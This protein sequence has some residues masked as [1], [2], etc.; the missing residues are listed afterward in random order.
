MRRIIA[1]VICILGLAAPP[2][3]HAC[4]V[5]VELPEASI[6]DQILAAEVVVFAGPAPENPF[7]YSTRRIFRGSDEKL[8]KAPNIPFLI[9]SVTRRAF[10]ADPTTMV[11][12]IYGPEINDKAG[13]NFSRA[14]R[15]IFVMNPERS[16]FIEQLQANSGLWRLGETD[17]A[18]R[19]SFFS[20]YLWHR[21]QALHDMAMV[22]IGRANYA[23]LRPIGGRVSTSQIME[24]LNDLNRF[25]YWPVAIRLLGLQ[26]DP[27]ARSIVRSRF[28]K[29]LRS[30][31]LHSH[32]WALAGIEADRL[33]AINAIGLALKDRRKTREDKDALV[34]ALSDAGSSQKQFQDEII[35]VFANVLDSDPELTLQIAVATRN[36]GETALH[37]KFEA[38]V[39]LEETDPATQ[40]F[41]NMVLQENAASE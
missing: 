9:D 18:A 33:H 13:R 6:S 20:D 25:A 26:T 37:Q 38:L 28:A 4:V 34:R 23:Y 17:N 24:E 12:L 32:E 40:F 27:Q 29:S 21:D 35:L 11:L 36:W 5:C 3:L 16:E 19:V 39:A 14:W 10:R 41:L 8:S 15:R 22:E 31:G 2:A 7:E 30:G 1:A